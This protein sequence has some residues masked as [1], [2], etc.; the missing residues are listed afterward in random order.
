M[1]KPMSI[2]GISNAN[3]IIFWKLYPNGYK[4]IILVNLLL[5]NK[6]AFNL[7]HHHVFKERDYNNTIISVKIPLGVVDRVKTIFLENYFSYEMIFHAG[8]IW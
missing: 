6:M 3:Q 2:A 4:L 7:F 1:T 8:C 5:I